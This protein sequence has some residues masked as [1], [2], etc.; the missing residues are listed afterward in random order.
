M[1]EMCA[2]TF[3]NFELDYEAHVHAAKLLECFILQC[4]GRINQFIPDILQVVMN[5]LHAGHFENSNNELVPQ[6]LVVFIAAM[7]YNFEFFV[8]CLPNLTPYGMETVQ[9]LFSEIFANK[10]FIEG[11]H[12]R[13]MVLYA[14][15]L[16]LR[17]PHEHQPPAIA[18]NAKAVTAFVLELFDGIAKCQKALAERKKEEM[19][20]SDEEESDSDDENP[21]RTIDDELR[22]SDDDIDEG[23]AF[24]HGVL[25]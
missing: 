3:T 1:L 7:H 12:N 25:N 2:A 10:E 24:S 23:K 4:P 9:W 5:R 6:L 15:C 20:S 16:M 22:D 18:N 11:I 17:L 21:N 14:I 19:E 13:K 8:Q